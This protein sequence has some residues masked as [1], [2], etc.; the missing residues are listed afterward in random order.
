[1]LELA[2]HA[3]YRLALALSVLSSSKSSKH[4]GAVFN[5]IARDAKHKLS[6]NKIAVHSDVG[7]KIK[8]I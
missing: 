3:Y 8:Y 2:Y 6:I 1:M 7:P 5:K 4:F